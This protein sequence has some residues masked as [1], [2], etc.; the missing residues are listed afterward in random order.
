MK[1]K[2]SQRKEGWKKELCEKKK[3]EKKSDLIIYFIFIFQDSS[4]K[5]PVSAG[6]DPFGTLDP[7]SSGG[8]FSMESN[9]SDFSSTANSV[10]SP[11]A[12]VFN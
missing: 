1:K 12:K 2:S 11:T 9:K 4:N 5:D 10:Q 8:A 3:Q 6:S 7:F